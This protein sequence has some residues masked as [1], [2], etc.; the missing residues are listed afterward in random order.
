MGV[1]ICLM[2]KSK[3]IKMMKYFALAGLATVAQS[4]NIPYFSVEVPYSEQLQ[5]YEKV[6]FQI[7]AGAREDTCYEEDGFEDIEFNFEC[8]LMIP[9]IMCVTTP[10]E[11]QEGT[12]FC[13][14]V[15]VDPLPELSLTEILEKDGEVN[16]PINGD[17]EDT[18][19]KKLREILNLIVNLISNY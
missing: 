3:H 16:F 12:C 17:R 1:Y 13:Y 9:D 10:C 19:Y 11:P 15:E 4:I 7:S 6:E 8:N 18:C 5:K 2:K 14:R